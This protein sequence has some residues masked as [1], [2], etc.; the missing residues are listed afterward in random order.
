MLIGLVAAYQSESNKA[1]NAAQLAE[2]IMAIH[3]E[4]SAQNES[5]FI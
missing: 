2:E 1:E 3:D 5:D 4:V